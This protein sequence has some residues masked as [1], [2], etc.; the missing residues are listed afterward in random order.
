VTLA[1][2]HPDELCRRY[3]R[4]EFIGRLRQDIGAVNFREPPPPE[5]II[6]EA[7]LPELPAG[8]RVDAWGRCRVMNEAGNAYRLVHPLERVTDPA[9]LDR[10][11]FPDLTQ[12]ECHSHLDEA[13]RSLHGTGVAVQGHMSQTVFE[14]AW[15]LCG[16]ERALMDLA[17][18]PEFM[19][20]M[21]DRLLELRVFQARRYAQAGVD[22]LRVGDDVGAQRGM[23]ISPALW[24][25]HLKPRLAKVIAA[26]RDL[27]PDISINYHSDGDVRAVI[28][29][30][31]EIGVTILNPIQPECMEPSEIKREYGNH[32]TLLGTI[33]TQSTL[34]KAPPGDV[35]AM[36]ARRI[37]ECAPGGGF[38]IAP[39]HSIRPEVPWENVMAFFAAAEEFGRYPVSAS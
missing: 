25:T 2:G 36:V 18:G 14:M 19:L 10:F 12:L 29:D 33:G 20:A 13:V 30:L 4:P 35:A 34:P 3:G 8:A 37:R 11:P 15:E 28:P 27:N 24:R 17:T 21:F 1:Y 6:R 22:I 5:R 38:V 39:T 23:M 31:I 32:L 7:F 9:E 16:M 26:A